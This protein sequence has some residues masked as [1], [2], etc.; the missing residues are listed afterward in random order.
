[1]QSLPQENADF[2]RKLSEIAVECG[3]LSQAKESAEAAL[4]SART[5][6]AALNERFCVTAAEAAASLKKGDQMD[7]RI[8]KLQRE[9]DDARGRMDAAVES[10]RQRKTEVT[11]ME[12]NRQLEQK[13]RQIQVK[14]EQHVCIQSD[15]LAAFGLAETCR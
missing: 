15:T 9:L 13:K 1:M 10:A 5:E 2:R 11:R 4:A 12:E 7:Q 14:C 8:M 3:E 6:M